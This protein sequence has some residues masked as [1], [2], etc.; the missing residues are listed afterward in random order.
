MSGVWRCVS[1][2][3]VLHIVLPLAVLLGGSW[4][5]GRVRAFVAV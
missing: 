4:E 2:V 1:S 5:V 3:V